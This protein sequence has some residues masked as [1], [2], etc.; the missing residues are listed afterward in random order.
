[1]LYPDIVF[2]AIASS[3]VTHAALENWEY[4]DII[5]AAAEPECSKH[6]VT[7]ISVIDGLL[8][9]PRLREALKGLF[10]LAELE[11]DDDFAS[12]LEV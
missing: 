11:H 10:G 2:G 6:L 1:M 4:M 7:S 12:V 3:G 5:R 8:A 9:V